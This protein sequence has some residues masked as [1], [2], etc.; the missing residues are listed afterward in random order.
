[1]LPTNSQV[2]LPLRGREREDELLAAALADKGVR[3]IV[4][5]GAAGIGKSVFLE[6]ALRRLTQDGALTGA[7]KHVEGGGGDD[8]TPLIT[9]LEQAVTAG[10]DQLYD[11]DAGMATLVTAVGPHGA[12]FCHVG[13]GLLRRLA[14]HSSPVAMPPEA[15]EE[16][17]IQGILAV[18]RW[19]EGFNQ[20]IVLLIDDW[21]RAS[22]RGSRRYARLLSEPALTLLRFLTTERPQEPSSVTAQV[23]AVT[24]DV[25]L[26]DVT[27]LQAVITDMLGDDS[28]AVARSI[29]DFVP[30]PNGLAFDLIQAVQLLIAA[31][32]LPRVDGGWRFDSGRAGSALGESL[33]DAVAG[34]LAL[35]ASA[36]VRL[37]RTLAVFGDAASRSDILAACELTADTGQS[38]IDQLER[39]GVVRI[40][41]DNLFLAHDRIRAAILA[42]M[43]EAERGQSAGH[44][45]EVLRG[46][47]V[48]SEDGARGTSMLSLRLRGGLEEVDGRAW[49]ALFAGGA[50]AARGSGDGVAAVSFAEAALTLAERSAATT[51]AV[52]SEA[53]LA[54]VQQI[55]HVQAQV[56]ADRLVE[57]AANPR[58]LAEA[59]EIRVFTW[60]M[61]GDL[62]KALDVGLDASRR[63]GFT[64]PARPTQAQV[65]FEALRIVCSSPTKARTKGA[66]AQSE[67]DLA[68]PMLRVLNATGTLLHERNARQAVILGARAAKGRLLSGTALGASVASFVCA[69]TGAYEK[70]ASWAE[71]SDALQSP[72]QP[73]RAAAM[74]NAIDFGHA[75][76]RPIAETARRNDEVE[77]I[78]YAEGD[79]AT[80]GYANRNRVLM[81]LYLDIPLSEVIREAEHGLT[82]AQRLQDRT[83]RPVICAVLQMAE[84]LTGAGSK[85]SVLD[86]AHYQD[87]P[88]ALGY[89][90][91]ERDLNNL[92]RLIGGA[93]ALLADMFGDYELAARLYERRR[94]TFESNIHHP[95]TARWIFPSALALY[96]TGRKPPVRHLKIM[97]RV[98]RLNPHNQ[99][100]RMLLL[101]AERARV[102]GRRRAALDLYEEAVAAAQASDCIL[103]RGLIS[104]A[105]AEG[106]EMLHAPAAARGFRE[107]AVEAW[108]AFGAT[109]LLPAGRHPAPS[110]DVR[111]MEEELSRLNTQYEFREVELAAARDAAERANRAKSRLLASVGHELRTPLQGIA[112]LVELA[113][114]EVEPIDLQ[115]LRGAV[116]Q[117]ATVVGDLTDLGALDAE[118]L[119]LAASDFDPHLQVAGVIA[120]HQPSLSGTGRR[121]IQVDEGARTVL[122]GDPGR[123]RQIVSNLI[124]NAVKHGRGDISVRVSIEAVEADCAGMVVEVRDE[125][126]GL[127]SADLTRIFEPF[128]RGPAA[129]RITGLGLG[130]SI[131]RRLAQAMDGDLTARSA[132]GEGAIF[133]LRLDLPLSFSRPVTLSSPRRSLRVL[134]AEDTPLSRRVLSALVR[135]EGCVVDEAEDGDAA[136]SLAMQVDFDLMI[137]DM[138]M[139]GRDGLAV[140]QAVRCGA[141]RN[142]GTP[143]A[144]VTASATAEVERRAAALGIEAVLQKPIGR[145][146]LQR[147]LAGA[148]SG[149]WAPTE[150]VTD[151]S[152][153]HSDRLAELRDIL[154]RAEAG[155]LLAQVKPNILEAMDRIRNAMESGEAIAAT[156]EAHRLAGLTSHFGL[157]VQSGAAY[158][159]ETLLERPPAGGGSAELLP[160]M[161]SLQSAIEH[162]DWTAFGDTDA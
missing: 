100:H 84:N 30:A 88:S 105:A 8:L 40:D 10:L 132:P 92:H 7:G 108:T 102:A 150:M 50:R 61:S 142:S 140:T 74:Q 138:H 12:A 156:R 35:M 68:G 11:P 64:V 43:S 144:I 52:L 69:L 123:I 99:R 57:L 3:A 38:V 33:A 114:L 36:E 81:S 72:S 65:I 90:D 24:I 14:D 130:L 82:I 18:L 104:Q 98:A 119:S 136:L 44:S 4:A 120:V 121:I 53:V 19:L 125:G 133:R 80:A 55:D 97:R 67:L 146:E 135:A 26:L 153:S 94:V 107:S 73:L 21:G 103:D 41:G 155:V 86:G 122:V 101:D 152:A 93:E 109:N 70:A 51:F 1:M 9:A 15:G 129:D 16:R 106:A 17:L 48:T 111:D 22:E 110:P 79:L 23:E 113:E 134:L 42:S 115:V 147:L 60:R 145:N 87:D 46:A 59:D 161:L 56:L 54:A 127:S 75:Y 143:I 162:I 71:V 158:K 66:V 78:A 159:L 116:G 49:A 5:R 154:G 83:T 131:A 151:A 148:E 124:G 157:T 13:S 2:R 20:P 77:A 62:Q 126:A 118:A 89:A 139:P 29:L 95:S 160:A 25:S 39:A 85:G 37:A 141:A 45:A 91:S 117:L 112:G 28:A 58:E 63:V 76:V 31:D 47:G 27:A 6:R 34:R 128:E 96:R 149:Q 32:A 137:L